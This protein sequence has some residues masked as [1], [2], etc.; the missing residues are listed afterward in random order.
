MVDTPATLQ[1][2]P[3]SSALN[4]EARQPT[5]SV[6]SISLPRVLRLA[7]PRALRSAPAPPSRQNSYTGRFKVSVVEWQRKNEVE[8]HTRYAFLC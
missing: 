1:K 6:G 2:R 7:T 5:T 3:A 8:N 4:A